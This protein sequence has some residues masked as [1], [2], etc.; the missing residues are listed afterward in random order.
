MNVMKLVHHSGYLL[1]FDPAF[2]ALSEA[3]SVPVSV[4]KQ[5]F[6]VVSD[7][8]VSIHSLHPRTL[9]SAK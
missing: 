3:F 5:L 8:P 6:C 4:S 2:D 7:K 1:E 9:L